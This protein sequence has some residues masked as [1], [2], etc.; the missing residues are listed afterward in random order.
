M[1]AGLSGLAGPLEREYGVATLVMHDETRTKG[2]FKALQ[3]LWKVEAV[4]ALGRWCR[5]ARSFE[6]TT[7][8][9]AAWMQVA[10]VGFMLTLL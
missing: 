6:A 7:A 8:S 1:L 9:S 2:E 5:P 4:S 3:P 10:T